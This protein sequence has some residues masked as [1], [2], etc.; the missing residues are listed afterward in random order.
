MAYVIVADGDGKVLAQSDA[1]PIEGA[2]RPAR[3]PRRPQ[4]RRRSSRRIGRARRRI[5][6]FAVPLVYSQVPVG[7]LYLGF[8]QRAIDAALA[9]ARNEAAAITLVM[10]VARHRRRRGPGHAPLAAHRPARRGRRAPS[11]AGNFD[12]SLAVTSRDEIGALTESFNQMARSLREK[13]MIKRAFT[14]YVAREVVEEIL[15]DP[16]HLVLTGERREVTV[17]FCDVRGFTP[18]SERLS[19]RGGRPPPQRLLHAD[20]RDDVQARR[21]PRQVP[22]RRA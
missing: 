20:D 17:L 14:R 2:D 12:V 13:E 3:R 18:L 11:R 8:S 4:G 21:D 1:S 5:I 9:R 6:D 7:A 10:V 22:R 15:K 19:S 16:E